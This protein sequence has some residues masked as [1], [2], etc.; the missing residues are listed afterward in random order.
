MLLITSNKH[1][2]LLCMNYVQR[3]SP[4]ELEGAREELKAVL[5]ELPN[6][7]R[8]LADLSQVEFMDPDCA[9][10]MGRA[11]DLFDQRGVSLILRVIPDA[12]KDIGLNILTAF[13]YPHHPRVISCR[14]LGEA[15]HQLT[16][17]P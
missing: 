8:L 3:V 12:S 10:E 4:A 7:F 5:A 11:M 15:L 2:R 14:N 1:Q 17:W 16:V 9:A 13:H 6:G